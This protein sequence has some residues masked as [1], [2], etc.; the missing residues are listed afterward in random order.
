METQWR[1]LFLAKYLKMNRNVLGGEPGKGN[2]PNR[3]N[4]GCKDIRTWNQHGAF[5][6]H[7]VSQLAAEK[8]IWVQDI[9]KGNKEIR[10]K[11]STALFWR[12]WGTQQWEDWLS[13]LQFHEWMFN[14]ISK[15][16]PTTSLT[17]LCSMPWGVCGLCKSPFFLKVWA[18]WLSPLSIPWKYDQ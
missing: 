7:Q 18:V 17:A 15:A 13:C 5:R 16:F 8:G 4:V 14:W 3:K 1:G 6:E 11:P 2:P 10:A 9:N 12:Q